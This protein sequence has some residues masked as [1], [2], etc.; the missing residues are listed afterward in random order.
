MGENKVGQI[1]EEEN[2]TRGQNEIRSNSARDTKD[3]EI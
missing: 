3:K 1:S 2:G